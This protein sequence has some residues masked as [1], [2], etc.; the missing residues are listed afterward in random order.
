M[1]LATTLEAPYDDVYEPLQL[2]TIRG[3]EAFIITNINRFNLNDG[4]MEFTDNGAV[5]SREFQLT[6]TMTDTFFYNS[7]LGQDTVHYDGLPDNLSVECNIGSGKRGR[8]YT[9]Y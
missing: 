5:Y 1:A 9:E 4:I 3:E 8:F 2:A 7:F 6:G